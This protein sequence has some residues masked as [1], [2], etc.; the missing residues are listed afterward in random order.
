M[1][2]KVCG[3]MSLLIHVRMWIR[4]MSVG[5]NVSIHNTGC[6]SECGC[7]DKCV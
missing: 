6:K 3:R 7:V 1:V 2:G 4:W 5:I